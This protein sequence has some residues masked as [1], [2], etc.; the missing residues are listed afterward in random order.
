MA[1]STFAQTVRAGEKMAE[2]VCDVERA[3]AAI[4]TAVEEGK[5]AARRVVIRGR[6]A[7]EDLQ[8]DALRGVRRHPGTT[9]AVTFG[10]AMGAGLLLGWLVGRSRR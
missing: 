8:E 5:Q 6:R 1:E 4:S 3:K 2:S 7:A 9:V 10:V